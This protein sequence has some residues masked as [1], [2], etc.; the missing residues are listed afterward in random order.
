VTGFDFDLGAPQPGDSVA[1][2]QPLAQ[3]YTND[4]R[5]LMDAANILRA[6]SAASGSGWI[7]R[8]LCSLAVGF[9]NGT[10]VMLLQHAK[11]AK[12]NPEGA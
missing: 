3:V 1:T 8:R 6:Y 2:I 10:A 9:L 11:R 7:G 5:T 12:S 4:A